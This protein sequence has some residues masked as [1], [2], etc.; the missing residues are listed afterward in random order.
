MKPASQILESSKLVYYESFEDTQKLNLISQ[1]L[2]II[3][4][5][6]RIYIIS[7]FF[8]QSA[9]LFLDDYN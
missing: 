7:Y 8:L 3:F 9:H 2:Q 1:K 6:L 4:Q 5:Q